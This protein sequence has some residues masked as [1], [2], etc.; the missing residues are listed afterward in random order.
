MANNRLILYC[1]IC[2]KGTNL[3]KYYP[4]GWYTNGDQTTSLNMFF[5]DHQNCLEESGKD[6]G[7]DADIFCLTTEMTWEGY[8]DVYCHQ[9]YKEEPE[10][11]GEKNV[12]HNKHA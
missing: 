7:F 8:I 12:D 11:W 3:A 9:L 4:V 10:W 5:K 1:S 6:L 2:L